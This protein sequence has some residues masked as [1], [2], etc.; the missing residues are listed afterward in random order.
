M[1]QY[2]ASKLMR[3]KKIQKKAVDFALSKATPFIQK[4]SVKM[5][6][7]LRTK[8]RPNRNIKQKEKI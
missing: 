6:D 5:L 2:G 3:N 7:Q 8:I 1:G 4:T